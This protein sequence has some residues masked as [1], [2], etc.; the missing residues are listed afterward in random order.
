MEQILRTLNDNWGMPFIAP[1]YW[2]DDDI[3]K[4]K[5]MTV[6]DGLNLEIVSMLDFVTEATK[7]IN[8][9]KPL[10]YINNLDYMKLPKK[11]ESIEELVNQ[12][13]QHRNS[14]YELFQKEYQIET[15]QNTQEAVDSERVPNERIK[16]QNQSE[17]N[18]LENK[19]ISQENFSENVESVSEEKMTFTDKNVRSLL[20]DYC[21]PFVKTAYYKE[22]FGEQKNEFTEEEIRK[23]S[24]S[25]NLGDL[26]NTL[27][28]K[29]LRDFAK[30]TGIPVS[31]DDERQRK[32]IVEGIKK[33]QKKETEQSMSGYNDEDHI[34]KMM[35]SG[36]ENVQVN[37]GL[38]EAAIEYE[39][40]QNEIAQAQEE[41]EKEE[42]SVSKENQLLDKTNNSLEQSS[43]D[44]ASEL[45]K[46]IKFT[47]ENYKKLLNV[48]N[49]ITE[50]SGTEQIQVPTEEQVQKVSE[51]KEPQPQTEI[52]DLDNLEKKQKVETFDPNA[53]VVYGKTVLPAFT[54]MSEGK[55]HSVEN[56]VVMKFNKA[57]QT[58]L[59]DN[60]SEKLELPT[61]TF[62]TLLKDKQE[63][64]EKIKVAE[65]RT[66][67]FQ[68]KERGIDGTVIPEFAMY[69]QHG[70][71]T[72]KD[73]VPVKHNP[74]DDSYVISNGDT[75]MTVT[76]ERFKEITAPE[77]FEN[78]FDENSPAWKKLC[79]QEYKDFF[80]PRVNT[81]YNF[82]HNLSVYCRKEANSPCDALHLAKDIISR[83][84]KTEQKQTEKILKTMAH[85]NESTNEVITRL[86]HEAIKEQPLNEDYI[87]K[88]QPDNV[89]ARPMYDTI[90]TNGSKIE[91]E[92]A[93]IRGTQDRNLTIG[94][95]LK[96]INIETG[97]VFGDKK[98]SM[99]FDELK[100][101]SASKEGNS[102]TVMDSNKSFIQ[103]PRDT[104]LNMYR[105]QQIKEMKQ[106]QRHYRTNSM[107]ISYV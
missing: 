24:K 2:N 84:S 73:F 76:A 81:A 9:E 18:I 23:L 60:G 34:N 64:E 62:E 98:D 88:Y 3:S 42:N 43:L 48:I 46:G 21:E 12:E 51:E 99:H 93:L 70:L 86:Y 47:P 77:R 4:W 89:I 11:I 32:L 85:E 20:L 101:I 78:K 8:G 29:S 25:I 27:D 105:E 35:D 10:E 87:K 106:E 41:F 17:N 107:N 58:Y 96:N 83:M 6:K 36:I 40:R 59:I 19:D 97:S 33:L 68:D 94:T 16:L 79:E 52:Q 45:L 14:A 100:V 75:T 30:D 1:D 72:F 63:Q 67:V 103:L 57:N 95:I 90:S 91:N 39:N 61:K 80:E 37:G 7:V 82:R 56:A 15:Q 28:E 74:A 71:E 53:P 66:I 38:S 44:K 102:I 26:L 13:K 65:G 55:L 69:T 54:V 5:E 104:V 49:D 50:M 92:P 31:S 22:L